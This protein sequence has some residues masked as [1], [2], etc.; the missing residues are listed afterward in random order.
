[1][2][3]HWWFYSG[4]PGNS[5]A[6][7]VLALLAAGKPIVDPSLK[8]MAAT[9]SWGKLEQMAA[10]KRYG[11]ESTN[12]DGSLDANTAAVSDEEVSSGLDRGTS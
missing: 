6:A 10:V 4:R 3:T 11:P 7:A 5:A 12:P 1:M 2:L 9:M 8:A